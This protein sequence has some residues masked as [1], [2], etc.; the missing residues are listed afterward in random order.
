[1]SRKGENIYKRKDSRWE[2]R[3]IKEHS[4]DGKVKYGY[5]YGKTYAEAKEKANNSKICLVLDPPRKGCDIKVINS[6]I[7][8]DIEKIV[9]EIG[10]A[11]NNRK[12]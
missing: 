12:Q 9:Y 1:M 11:T 5:C 3:Y 6:I 2:A 8:S 7:N 4:P 10:K